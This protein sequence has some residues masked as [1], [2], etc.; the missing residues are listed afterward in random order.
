MAVSPEIRVYEQ[1]I[2]SLGVLRVAVSPEN[3]GFQDRAGAVPSLVNVRV[4][5]TMPTRAQ[6]KWL[7]WQPMDWQKHQSYVR[8]VKK[9]KREVRCDVED[10]SNSPKHFKIINEAVQ[11]QVAECPPFNDGSRS[12]HAVLSLCRATDYP[13]N[14]GTSCN[15]PEKEIETQ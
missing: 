12:E 5:V 13:I 15:R 3:K 2:T 14:C 9:E 7:G 4:D 6:Q 10:L 1:G 11:S 8:S